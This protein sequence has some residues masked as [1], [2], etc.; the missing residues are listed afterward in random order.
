MMEP[1]PCTS[2]PGQGIEQE[3]KATGRGELL[4]WFSGETV[5]EQIYV[6]RQLNA[7]FRENTN[8]TQDTSSL[9]NINL[10]SAPDPN[11]NLFLKPT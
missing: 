3:R 11:I 2:P 7:Q 10:L 9:F 8:S 5:A 6:T 1:E 4:N